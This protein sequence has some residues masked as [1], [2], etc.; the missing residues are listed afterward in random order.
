MLSSASKAEVG[1]ADAIVPV[2]SFAGEL[3]VLLVP[4]A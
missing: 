3:F 1:D 2:K 4:V